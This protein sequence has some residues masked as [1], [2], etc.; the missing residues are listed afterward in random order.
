MSFLREVWAFV[1]G[2]RQRPPPGPKSP[3]AT[4]LFVVASLAHLPLVY[5]LVRHDGMAPPLPLA[6][7]LLCMGIAW[8]GGVALEGRRRGTTRAF[9]VLGMAEGAL[10]FVPMLVEPLGS[11][12]WLFV[13]IALLCA[14]ALT[15]A[16]RAR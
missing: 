13:L 16:V 3:L 5:L 4:G 8:S 1:R 15:A 2:T 14:G 11:A 12:R 10:A 6:I 9:A 7:G